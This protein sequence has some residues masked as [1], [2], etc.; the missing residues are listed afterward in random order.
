MQHDEGHG[1]QPDSAVIWSSSSRQPSSAAV[2]TVA[3]E[4]RRR[5]LVLQ[6][7]PE[8]PGSVASRGRP[9]PVKIIACRLPLVPLPLPVRAE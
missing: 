2:R 4:R 5:P 7:Q 9:F 8:M 1:R 3:R 6:E